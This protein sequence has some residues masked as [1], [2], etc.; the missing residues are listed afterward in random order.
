M[1]EAALESLNLGQLGYRTLLVEVL[2]PAAQVLDGI[3][4]G[5]NL[6]PVSGEDLVESRELVEAAHNVRE[7]DHLWKS[8]MLFSQQCARGSYTFEVSDYGGSSLL[9]HEPEEL[10]SFVLKL[11]VIAH[12]SRQARRVR[13]G[14]LRLGVLHEEP[15]QGHVGVARR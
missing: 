6:D 10:D 4:D 7:A 1:T 2:D 8:K 15:E 11:E 5:V 12:L 14:V 13:P 3:S 9:E